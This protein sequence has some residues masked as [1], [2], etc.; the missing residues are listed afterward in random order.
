MMD[1]ALPTLE[2][3]AFRLEPLNA[4]HTDDLL[5]AASEDQIWTYLDEETPRTKAQIDRFIQD[6]IDEH[7]RG[8]RLPFAVIDRA[9]EKAIGSISLID[10][11]QAHRGIEVGWAWISPDYWRSG[12]SREAAYLL[13]KHAFEKMGAIRAAFKTD[14]R[15]ARSQN[16]I[17]GMGATQEG[18]FRNHRILSDGY[19]RDSIYYSIL[20]REWPSIRLK[21]EADQERYHDSS[22]T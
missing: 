8:V 2:G 17:L 22:A 13:L 9:S 18:T 19:V 6:A 14:S 4:S 5:H 15:N 1:L 10:I 11:Q 20:D 7:G 21:M 16:L 3:K 12:A